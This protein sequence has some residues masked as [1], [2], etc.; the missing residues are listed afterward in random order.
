MDR[1]AWNQRY[2]SPD[3]V[4]TA[5][6]NRTVA[7]QVADLE[8][9]RALDLATGEGRNA[10]WLAEQGW[11]VT[12][13]DFSDA[14]IA[15]GR[16]MAA[17]RDV[18]VDWVV[19]DVTVHRPEPG[20]YDLVLIAY[21]HLPAAQRH[22]VMAAAREA[23]APGGTFLLVGHDLSNIEHGHGGPQDPAVLCTPDDIAADLPG[24]DIE[25]AEVLERVVALDPGHGGPSEAVAL[26]TFVRAR[27]PA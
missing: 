1:D 12:A 3:L 22:S 21:L 10:I 24:F 6:P 13:V 19:D 9:G 15:T 27:R 11:R 5:T 8:P 18:D 14:G 25:R 23:V 2:S 7:E 26:D 16:R 20:A 17:E 4:W